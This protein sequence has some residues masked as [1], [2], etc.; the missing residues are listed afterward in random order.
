MSYILQMPSLCSPS[1][2]FLTIFSLQPKSTTTRPIPSH[3]IPHPNKIEAKNTQPPTLPRVILNAV[4][5]HLLGSIRLQVQMSNVFSNG[6]HHLFNSSHVVIHLN[7]SNHN[8]QISVQC[9][10]AQNVPLPP[11]ATHTYGTK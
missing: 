10:W 1:A 8:P 3:P 6:M 11:H 4:F 9:S 2:V 7:Q 5:H